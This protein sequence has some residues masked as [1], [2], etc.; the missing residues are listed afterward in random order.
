VTII[1]FSLSVPS[2][3][4]SRRESQEPGGTS[5]DCSINREFDTKHELPKGRNSLGD[6]C[7]IYAKGAEYSRVIICIV[8]VPAIVFQNVLCL[9]QQ[10]KSMCSWERIS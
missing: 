1:P 3:Q 6:P 10:E 8:R 5:A 4:L 2:G 7:V 9:R